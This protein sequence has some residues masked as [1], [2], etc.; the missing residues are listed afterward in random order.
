[1]SSSVGVQNMVHWETTKLYSQKLT[2]IR[3]SQNYSR[4]SFTLHSAKWE[5]RKKIA[6]VLALCSPEPFPAH[7]IT[8]SA[9]KR[10]NFCYW[11]FGFWIFTYGKNPNKCLILGFHS[12][13]WARQY[14]KNAFAKYEL[15]P[16]KTCHT[17]WPCGLTYQPWICLQNNRSPSQ[18]AAPIN[19]VATYNF[20]SRFAIVSSVWM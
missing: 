17:A 3:S 8:G 2:T 12:R 5:K 9:Q 19:K 11:V 14:I 10:S 7:G 18:Q 6:S 13:C 1:M 16:I 4:L 20:A 15:K